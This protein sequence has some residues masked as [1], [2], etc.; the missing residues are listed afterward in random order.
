MASPPGTGTAAAASL[1]EPG[2]WLHPG[3]VRGGGMREAGRPAGQAAGRVSRHLCLRRWPGT[4]MRDLV[5]C[6][7][8][9]RGPQGNGVGR[10]GL[11]ITG[12]APAGRSG[13]AGEVWWGRPARRL[14]GP[15]LPLGGSSGVARPSSRGGQTQLAAVPTIRGQRPAVNLL[16]AGT[17]QERCPAP[18]PGLWAPRGRVPPAPGKQG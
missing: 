14:C 10:G 5:G 8:P 6:P 13:R 15:P 17:A 9:G 7:G 18:A 1:A 2:A 11:V 16:S 4:E 3:D 12:S